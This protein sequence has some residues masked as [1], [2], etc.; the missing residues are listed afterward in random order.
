MIKLPG[1]PF[2]PWS[3]FVCRAWGCH[4]NPSSLVYCCFPSL[5]LRN[6]IVLNSRA[7]ANSKRW[8]RFPPCLQH[9]LSGKMIFARGGSEMPGW[10]VTAPCPF[11]ARVVSPSTS[12]MLQL[13]MSKQPRNPPVPPAGTLQWRVSPAWV[14]G[15][16]GCLWQVPC[17]PSLSPSAP[18][19]EGNQ[20]NA[21]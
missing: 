11:G 15:D 1:S 8:D 19:I 21:P 2:S 17:S 4:R 14:S 20:L 3:P 13:R 10:L 6:K 5:C 16:S 12:H 9:H 18:G 7:F